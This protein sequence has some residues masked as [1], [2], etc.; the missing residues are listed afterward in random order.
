MKKD[1][2]G[3]ISSTTAPRP[4]VGL[5]AWLYPLPQEAAPT[6]AAAAGCWGEQCFAL[7]SAHSELGVAWHVTFGC[8]PAAAVELCIG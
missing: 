4:R 7:Q 1:R 5:R 8:R 6:A 2:R 3:R